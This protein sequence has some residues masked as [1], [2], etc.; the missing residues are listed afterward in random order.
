MTE[1]E[2]KSGNGPGDHTGSAS[3]I[4][5]PDILESKQLQA[6]MHWAGTTGLCG[7]PNY[8]LTGHPNP[9][10]VDVLDLCG[11]ALPHLVGCCCAC[12]MERPASLQVQQGTDEAPSA[13]PLQSALP[14]QICVLVLFHF[15]IALYDSYDRC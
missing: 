15:T 11:A 12:V 14:A 4:L 10:F 13:R 3:G 6:E 9:M 1:D 2:S 5:V 7:Q 8:V